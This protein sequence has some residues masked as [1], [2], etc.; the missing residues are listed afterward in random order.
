MATTSVNGAQKKLVQIELSADK[1]EKLFMKGELCVADIRCLNS[2]SKQS[3]WQLCLS[4][5]CKLSR[6]NQ[7]IFKCRGREENKL[8]LVEIKI[9]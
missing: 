8:R 2:E 5:C 1:L 3:I 7:P 6:A 4:C 9:Y